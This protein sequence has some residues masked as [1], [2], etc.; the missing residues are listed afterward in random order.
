LDSPTK[1]KE[2]FSASSMDEVFFELARGA[3]R[4]GD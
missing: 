2:Q 3:K 1:L 4:K